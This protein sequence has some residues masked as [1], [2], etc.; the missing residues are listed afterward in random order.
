MHGMYINTHTIITHTHTH[1]HSHILCNIDDQRNKY[2]NFHI[3]EVIGEPQWRVGG[4]KGKGKINVTLFQLKYILEI[5]AFLR[6]NNLSLRIIPQNR[7]HPRFSFF[8]FV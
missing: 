5:I 6:V 2:C 7:K 1:T 4:R 8:I 3:E